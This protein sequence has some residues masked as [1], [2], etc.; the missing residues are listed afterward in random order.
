MSIIILGM[1]V[2][3]ELGPTSALFMPLL[4]ALLPW[5]LH[6]RHAVRIPVQVCFA[7]AGIGHLAM[8]QQTG[9]QCGVNAQVLARLPTSQHNYQYH[10]Q[11]VH[12]HVERATLSGRP[13]QVPAHLCCVQ[14]GHFD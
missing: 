10:L 2:L 5:A 9:M 6:H 13:A 4:Q 14:T 3:L 7:G 8:L 12:R 1:F 11:C